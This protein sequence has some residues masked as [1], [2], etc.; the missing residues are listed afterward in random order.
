[1]K[2][3]LVFGATGQIAKALRAQLG[4]GAIFLSRNEADFMRPSD[5][6]AAVNDLQPQI[7]I[8]AVAYTQV[9]KC[10][11]E[12]EQA[13]QI[14]A[15]TPQAIANA[16]KNI[17]AK[18]VHYSTDYVFDGA[19]EV[20]FIEDDAANPLNNYGKSKRLGEELIIGSGVD[21]LI[22]RTSWVYDNCSNNFL[23]TMLR[24]GAQREEL[25]VVANQYG[26]PSYAP[27]LAVATLQ[28]LE[29]AK[30]ITKSIN[31]IY[32][33]CGAGE[34]SWHG[35]AEAIFAQAR[36]HGLPLKLTKCLPIP[37]SEYPT[38]AK[39]PHNSRLNCSKLADILGVE[40]PDWRVGLAEAMA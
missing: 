39:R 14:N 16:A 5:C 18:L 37:A 6:V 10:E 31:G 40:L 27:H 1:M 13:M 36:Q 24:L 20:A 34:T 33:M 11:I 17:G 21:Y 15:H 23:T 35:F 2:K 32:H 38:P 4:G 25:K 3:I 19:G 7:I 22:F 28:A 30:S 8:N 29:N 12:L 26:A 9:D